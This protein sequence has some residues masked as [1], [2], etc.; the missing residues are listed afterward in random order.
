LLTNLTKIVNWSH[1]NHYNFPEEF[2]NIVKTMLLVH[3]RKE[4]GNLLQYL[5]D[6]TLDLVIYF[7]SKHYILVSPLESTIFPGPKPDE[8]AANNNDDDYY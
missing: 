5:P 2:Q 6:S 4:E 1:S 7:L 8:D 3:N